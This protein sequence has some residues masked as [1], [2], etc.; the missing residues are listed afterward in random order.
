MIDYSFSM[1]EMEYYL[2]IFARITA[3]LFVAPFFRM[4]TVPRRFRVGLAVFTSYLIYEATFPHEV[5]E[6]NTVLGYAIIVLKETCAG[7][8]MGMAVNICNS[9]VNF[10]GRM[11]DMQVGLAMAQEYD[12]AS[13]E[14][15]SVSSVLYQYLVLMILVLS[16]MHTYLIQALAE[17][18][19]LI[20][21]NTAMFNTDALL[22][23]MIGYMGNYIN[24]GFQIALPVYCVMLIANCILGI[25][26]KV[27][28][29]MNMFAVGM[30][31]KLMMGFGVM[32]LTVGLLP[33]I[34][35]MI[36]T[37]LKRVLVS[38]VEAMM[39]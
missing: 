2:L 8:L 28:P 27:A 10:A 1:Y 29:Q 24:L 20:P 26:S 12:P 17:S 15:V 22:T 37:E 19:T 11:I 30:Q 9:I 6:Y 14:S 3:F 23:A 25:M 33:N 5:V 16:G 32:L 35:D 38:F 13:R 21:V 7:L 34:S 39:A 18:F 4:N 31:I 36:F